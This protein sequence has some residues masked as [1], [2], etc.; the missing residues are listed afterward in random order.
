MIAVGA[1]HAGVFLKNDI[2]KLLEKEGYEVKD[3][4]TYSDESCDYPIYAKAVADAV[5]SGLCEKGIL[6]CGT[7]IGMSMAAN[8]VKGIRAAVCSEAK[9]AEMTRRHN[10]ANILCLGARMIDE[11]TAEELVKIFLST[12]FEGGKHLRRISMFS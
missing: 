8:K 11:K 3:F 12:E 1:D 7:G 9:S 2:V 10:D 4:G 5:A 6:V